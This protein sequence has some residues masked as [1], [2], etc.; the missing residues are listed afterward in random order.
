MAAVNDVGAAA[1]LLAAE[2][3]RFG[4]QEKGDAAGLHQVGHGGV[5]VGDG[6]ALSLIHI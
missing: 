4:I 1:R 6:Q 2:Q 3:Q 5:A